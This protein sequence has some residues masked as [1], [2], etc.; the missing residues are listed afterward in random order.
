MKTP[1]VVLVALAVRTGSSLV[2]QVPPPAPPGAPV[3][4]PFVLPVRFSGQMTSS[5]ELYHASVIESRRP[6]QT[7]RLSLSPQA[8][9]FGQCSGG[10]NVL[11]S[12]EGSD[13]RQ[14]MSFHADVTI[15][16]NGVEVITIEMRGGRR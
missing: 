2:A 4:R 8:T 10:L 7:W 6:G 11:L 12:S 3:A 9:L 13:L 1:V 15:S 14:N 16:K 5:G